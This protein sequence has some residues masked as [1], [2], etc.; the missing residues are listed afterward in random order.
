MPSSLR[1]LWHLVIEAEA[2]QAQSIVVTVERTGP[3]D[4][5]RLAESLFDHPCEGRVGIGRG[6]EA[7]RSKTAAVGRNDWRCRPKSTGA[8]QHSGCFNLNQRWLARAL[9]F[10][11]QAAVERR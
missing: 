10:A 1:Q 7:S 3:V 2:R 6:A 5:H 11:D 9:L 4:W 8:D